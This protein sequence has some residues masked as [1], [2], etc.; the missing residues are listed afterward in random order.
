MDAWEQ[1][2]AGS[3]GVNALRYTWVNEYWHTVIGEWSQRAP[4]S[5]AVVTDVARDT[6][7]VARM[8]L[9][10]HQDPLDDEAS[11]FYP[12]GPKPFFW[13]ECQA[14]KF[15]SCNFRGLQV[16]IC[17]VRLNFFLKPHL[18]YL[19]SGLSS[20]WPRGLLH[21][22]L[23]SEGPLVPGQWVTLPAATLPSWHC[24]QPISYPQTS[25]QLS[26]LSFKKS[27]SNCWK[28][29]RRPPSCAQGCAAPCYQC[30]VPSRYCSGFHGN[31]LCA[32][33]VSYLQPSLDLT[34]KETLIKTWHS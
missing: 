29:F 2:K 8:A 18:L 5:L 20:L 14:R 30:G 3:W 11:P 21:L 12:A 33:I 7:Q 27:W 13:E 10:H 31:S 4:K 24:S 15:K 25:I 26:A 32:F 17:I 34:F 19:L 22:P 16:Q 9:S 28:C 23:N 6:L 1:D